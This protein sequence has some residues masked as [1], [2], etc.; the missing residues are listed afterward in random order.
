MHLNRFAPLPLLGTFLLWSCAT[1]HIQTTALGTSCAAAESTLARDWQMLSDAREAPG[2]CA[3][4]DALQ[5]KVERLSVDCPSNSNVMMANALLAFDGRNFVRAQQLLDELSSAGGVNPE[6]GVLRGRIAMEQGNMPFALKFLDQQ[7]HRT[8]DHAGLR[9]TYAS[10]L[11]L[12]NRWDE[13]REELGVAQRLGAPAWRTA[14]GLG[15]IEEALGRYEQ[16]KLRYQEAL[17][18]KPGWPPAASRLRTLAVSGR[19]PAAD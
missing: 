17:T 7:I 5:A 18:A 1:R 12:T 2:S 11:Y 15:L 16:A 19:V 3:N 10:A 6:A 8:G 9:E 4:C 13:A 14:Y